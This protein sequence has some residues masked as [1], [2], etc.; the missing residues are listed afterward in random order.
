MAPR[1][2]ARPTSRTGSRGPASGRRDDRSA[3]RST[4]NP[5]GPAVITVAGTAFTTRAL[6]LLAVTLLLIASY[7]S[8][9]HAWWEQRSEIAALERQTQDLQDD[10]AELEDLQERW[11]DPAFIKQQARARFGWVL[12]GE[13]GYRVIGTDGALRGEVAEL[14]DAPGT[15][16]K[17]WHDKL[18]TSF[19]QAG[20][21][22]T[23]P[24]ELPGDPDDVITDPDG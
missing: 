13:V 17:P 5:S 1:R 24:E 8:S 10:I 3:R 2:P 6:I 19:E 18:W 11:N 16:D 14:S 4:A 21:E 23:P 12:P 7:T 9:I 15:E 20:Q 22:P